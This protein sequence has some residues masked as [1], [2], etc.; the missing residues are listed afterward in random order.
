MVF[1]DHSQ[2][3]EIQ[4]AWNLIVNTAKFSIAGSSRSDKLGI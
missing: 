2:E 3:Q 4:Q 1:H